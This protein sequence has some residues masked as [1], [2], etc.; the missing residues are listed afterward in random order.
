MTDP[1][2]VPCVSIPYP[3]FPAHRHSKHTQLR[4]TRTTLF[5]CLSPSPRDPVLILPGLGN[6]SSD[7]DSLARQ[8]ETTRGHAAVQTVPVRRW[9]W[10]RNARG[11]FS[12]NYWSSTL[13]PSPFLDWYFNRTHQALQK[14]SEQFPGRSIS[15]L[16]HSA[17]G[18]L[19]RVYLS[20]TKHTDI[21]VSCLVTLGT[22]HNPPPTGR[23]DQTRGLLSYVAANCVN[24]VVPT[25]A[26][27]SVAGT[28]TIGKRVGNK[29]GSWNEWLAYLS[30]AAVC[31]DGHV[32]GDGVTPI[33]AAEAPNAKIIYCECSH[34]MLTNANNWYGSPHVVPQW[35]DYLL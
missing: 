17:G 4:R 12:R 31:G 21:R 28:G 23:L 35:A 11:F 16:G 26:F 2:F 19:A 33:T 25:G 10:A 32:D 9:D 30:Y 18:W 6:A 13:T 27:V 3:T 34:S 8:L 20:Q 7:Y 1:C 14:M 15:I 5:A 22:P 29:E 24:M